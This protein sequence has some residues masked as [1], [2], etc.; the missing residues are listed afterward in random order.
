MSQRY[1]PINIEDITSVSRLDYEEVTFPRTF[2]MF[3]SSK[4]SGFGMMLSPNT[5]FTQFPGRT[6]LFRTT[7]HGV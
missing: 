4:T 5:Y 3:P 1:D 6:Q 2:S 7:V